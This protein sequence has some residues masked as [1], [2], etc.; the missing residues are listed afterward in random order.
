M[1]KESKAGARAAETSRQRRRGRTVEEDLLF[2]LVSCPRLVATVANE[3]E[4]DLLHEAPVRALV[5]RF[6]AMA[7]D[8]K[9][10]AADLLARTQDEAERSVV[11]MIIGLEQPVVED[12]AAWCRELIGELQ[13]RAQEAVA[14]AGKGV[15]DADL[16]AKY[17]AFQEAQR[18]R[19]KFDLA[20]R[21]PSNA[22]PTS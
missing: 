20:G 1:A 12:S 17:A 8:G 3:L 9:P 10:T 21:S 13:A 14:V 15:E 6:L 16:K 18:Q 5:E 4:R 2:A 19:G 22:N 7:E 11:E